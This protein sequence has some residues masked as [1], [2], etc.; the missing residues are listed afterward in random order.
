[1][2]DQL[3]DE[4]QNINWFTIA[5]ITT[6]KVKINLLI[7]YLIMSLNISF[8]FFDDMPLMIS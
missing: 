8:P 3:T 4:A 7:N 5:E 1:M 6:K 2:G